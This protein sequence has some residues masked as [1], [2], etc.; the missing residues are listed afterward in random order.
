MQSKKK[1][2]KL[3][4]CIRLGNLN[5]AKKKTARSIEYLRRCSD[6]TVLLPKK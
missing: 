5:K 2:I 6:F 4:K 3:R 1:D